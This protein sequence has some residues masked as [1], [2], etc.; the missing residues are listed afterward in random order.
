MA[1][2]IAAAGKYDPESFTV[3][4]VGDR[5]KLEKELK[6]TFPTRTIEWH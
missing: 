2:L 5:K 6:A 3:V 4:L 1:E